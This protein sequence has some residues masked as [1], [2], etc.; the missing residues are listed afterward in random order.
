MS[1]QFLN[2]SQIRAVREKVRSERV[3]QQVRIDAAA[4]SGARCDFLCYLP[5]TLASQL[6]AVPGQK[7]LVPVSGAFADQFNS[8]LNKIAIDCGTGGL[9]DWNQSGFGALANN[10]H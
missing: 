2:D 6:L 7:N 5:N 4:K 9:S 8:F 10:T 1:Q 3:S